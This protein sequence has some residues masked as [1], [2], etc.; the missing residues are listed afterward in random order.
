M[1]SVGS[2]ADEFPMIGSSQHQI[3]VTQATKSYPDGLKEISVLEYDISEPMR[4]LLYEQVHRRLAQQE[5]SPSGNSLP[6]KVQLGM[7]N[8]PVLDQGRH[9]TCTTFAT[10]AAID[11]VLGRGDYVSQLCLLQLGNYLEAQGE[12]KSGWKG[13]S[14]SEALSRIEKY[15]IV[16]IKNQQRYSCGSYTFYPYSKTPS[17]GMSPEEYA[18]H[19]EFPFRQTVKLQYLLRGKGLRPDPKLIE[20][21]KTALHAGSRV[22]ISTLLPRTDLGTMGAT[23][24][25]RTYHYD[26]DTWVLTQ[27]IAQDLLYTTKQSGHAMVITGYDDQ[28][29]AKDHS[30]QIHQ[31]LFTLRNSWGSWV[32]DWGDFYMSYDYAETLINQSIEISKA[33]P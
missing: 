7:A 4:E 25:F 16:S 27:E 31:G 21:I 9:G 18:Q 32:G 8:V 3:P 33:H 28:A 6:K 14:Y 19:Q 2:F 30:G 1:S 26:D 24:K 5:V 23:G 13:A 15:G 22:L 11:A 29:K 12:G 17:A 10:T 20:K